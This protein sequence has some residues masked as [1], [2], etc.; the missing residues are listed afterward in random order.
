MG[1]I[2]GAAEKKA[3]LL[4]YYRKSG[5]IPRVW[6]FPKGASPASAA[7]LVGCFVGAG[8]S[9]GP[10][11]RRTLVRKTDG[12]MNWR[13]I[14]KMPAASMAATGRVKIQARAMLRMVENWSPLPL[15]AMVPA[16]PEERT[17]VVETGMWY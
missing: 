6:N 3:A 4:R 15:A 17:W 10:L 14:Q 5:P 16:T 12:Q 1:E 2:T 7:G 8:G 9:M 11:Q 13:M